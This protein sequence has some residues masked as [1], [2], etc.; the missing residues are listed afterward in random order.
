MPTKRPLKLRRHSLDG[1]PLDTQTSSIWY[2][3]SK[4]IGYASSTWARGRN[5]HRLELIVGISVGEP[6][7]TRSGTE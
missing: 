6:T 2:A 3:S 7:W 5:S 4:L 1:R